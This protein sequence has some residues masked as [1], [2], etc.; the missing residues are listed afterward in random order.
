M[1]TIATLPTLSQAHVLRLAL[2]A[3]DIA[4]VVLNE[5]A[6]G[7]VGGRVAVA[8][9]HDRDAE[10]ARAVVAGMEASHSEPREPA[11]PPVAAGEPPVAAL[12][13]KGLGLEVTIVLLLA[14]GALPWRIWA[15][16]GSHDV[17]RNAGSS[18]SGEIASSVYYLAFAGLALFLLWQRAGTL[19]PAGLAKLTWWRELL[20]G[21]AIVVATFAIGLLTT[22]LAS[23]LGL[24]EWA[25]DLPEGQAHGAFYPVFLLVA[26]FYEEALSRAYLITRFRELLGRP[27]PAVAASAVLFA[28]AHAASPARTLALFGS[29]LLWGW[30]FVS[31]RRLPRLVLAH[32]VWNLGVIYVAGRV[33]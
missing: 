12:P 15:A 20:Y 4:A 24:P 14:F 18:L 5:T 23:G 11:S 32:W 6:V 22:A 10:R 2:E 33:R 31:A 26:A 29:G 17:P 27:A 7:L 8:V 1:Q 28:L 9:L 19:E 16:L 30:I 13:R 3:E 21:A 25:S